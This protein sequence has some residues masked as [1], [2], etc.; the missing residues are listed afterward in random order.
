VCTFFT[1]ENGITWNQLGTTVAGTSGAIND[2]AS[3]PGIGNVFFAQ[4]NVYR[5]QL[6]NAGVLT[7]DFNPM[8]APETS[9][10]GTTWVSSTTGETW[11]L[12]STGANPARIIRT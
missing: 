10:N 7:N 5:A 1:G 12:V 3:N 2:S 11:T 8:D 4:S 9:V 6:Y